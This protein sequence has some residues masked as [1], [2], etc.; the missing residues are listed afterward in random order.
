MER[1]LLLIVSPPIE[2]MTDVVLGLPDLGESLKLLVW[3]FSLY[4][5]FVRFLTTRSTHFIY[6]Y[7]ASD[8]W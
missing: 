5:L 3:T 1:I 4:L 7:M 6:G 8:I 2:A